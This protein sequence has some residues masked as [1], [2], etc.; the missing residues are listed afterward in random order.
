M[1]KNR[2]THNVVVA[3][4]DNAKD[5]IEVGSG[6]M[7][8]QGWISIKLRPCVVLSDRDDIFISIYP[9]KDFMPTHEP[10]DGFEPVD[11]DD[12]QPK[13]MLVMKLCDTCRAPYNFPA[14][15]LTNLVCGKCKGG[16]P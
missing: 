2:P 16:S 14:S 1:A 11:D 10:D 8:E 12:E 5:R 7:N 15:Q 9:R 3:K 6:W 4:K 13:E